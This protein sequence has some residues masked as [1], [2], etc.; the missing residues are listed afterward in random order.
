MKP[1][2]LITYKLKAIISIL[3]MMNGFILISPGSGF[4]Y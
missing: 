1:P 3:F 4:S 2:P